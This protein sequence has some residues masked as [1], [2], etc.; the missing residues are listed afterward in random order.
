MKTATLQ[1]RVIVI[2]GSTGGLGQAAAQALRAKG[3]KLALLDLDQDKVDAQAR[4]L[5]G[6]QVAKGWGADV[7]SLSSLE[8]ALA[9]AALHFGRIDVVIANA[10]I[11]KPESMQYMDPATFER[12]IDINLNGV[13]RTFRAALP[14]V[15]RSRGYLLAVSS[16]AAFVHS[17]L[18][19]HYCAS[20]AAVWALCDSLRLELKSADVGV[21][22]LHPTFFQTPMMDAVQADPAGSSVWQDNTGIWKY[23][24]I[25]EVVA[26]LVD[27]I[28]RRRDMVTVPKQ[29]ALIARAPGLLRQVIER[30]G[31]SRQGLAETMQRDEQQHG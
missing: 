8:A 10:G 15:K 17:P 21:G 3:V 23:V 26:G 1:D 18:N 27:A 14:Y 24:A 9:S 25:D 29:N 30:V 4:T 7:R 12:T 6:D 5:G 19:T 13:F 11:G 16:M 31:F 20:K 28:V 2:T 22:S